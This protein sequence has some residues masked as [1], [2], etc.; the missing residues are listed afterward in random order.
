MITAIARKIS[1]QGTEEQNRFGIVR[2]EFL[3][4]LV[5]GV[6]ALLQGFFKAS[7]HIPPPAIRLH[8]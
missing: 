7:G 8:L 6:Q 5:D 4:Y 1:G 3:Y 2:F